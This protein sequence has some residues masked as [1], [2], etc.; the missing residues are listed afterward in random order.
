M[1]NTNGDSYSYKFDDLKL[2]DKHNN[3]KTI[4]YWN[5]IQY[6]CNYNHYN[7]LGRLPG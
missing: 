2:K 3:G 1:R 4:F 6:R 7:F 5:D